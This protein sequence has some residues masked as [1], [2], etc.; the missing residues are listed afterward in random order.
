[1]DW[2]VIAYWVVGSVIITALLWYF[3]VLPV[4]YQSDQQCGSLPFWQLAAK[5]PDE[6][7][8]FFL[9]EG[10]WFIDEVPTFIDRKDLYGPFKLFVPGLSRLVTIYCIADQIDNSQAEFIELMG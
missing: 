9:K 2:G 10:C 4:N 6:A 7:Y 1:M 3:R 8:Q 5:F